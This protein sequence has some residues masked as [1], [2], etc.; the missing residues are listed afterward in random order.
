MDAKFDCI[1]QEGFKCKQP[2][3]DSANITVPVRFVN[4]TGSYRCK[5]DGI[6]LENMNPCRFNETQVQVSE[7]KLNSWCEAHSALEGRQLIVNCAF[8]IDVENF[9]VEYNKTV[10]A[11][12]TK[13][14]C[15]TSDV[16][17]FGHNPHSA[18]VKLD[19]PG[20]LHG[21][22]R[23]HPDHP[24]LQLEVKSCSVDTKRD[25]ESNVTGDD[26]TQQENITVVENSQINF[27]FELQS[28]AEEKFRIDVKVCQDALLHRVCG[29]RWFAVNKPKCSNERNNFTCEVDNSGMHM[30]FLV[31]RT[32]SDIFWMNLGHS[33]TPALLKH[34]QLQVTCPPRLTLMST[35]VV[36]LTSVAD[37][38]S[39]GLRSYTSN[40]TKYLTKSD[41]GETI[42]E[43]TY[44]LSGHPPM[45][46]L[47]LRLA[48]KSWT[49]LG[50]W[51]L[52]VENEFG[53][54]SITFE[55]ISTIT[56]T[57]LSPSSE[58]PQESVTT[59]A[60]ISGCLLS[61]AAFSVGILLLCVIKMR[62]GVWGRRRSQFLV[63]ASGSRD[64]TE[65][66]QVGGL[67]ETGGFQPISHTVAFG[68]ELMEPTPSPRRAD[69]LIYGELEF[70]DRTPSN[71]II[72]SL[73]NTQY[74]QINFADLDYPSQK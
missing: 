58:D 15:Q 28:I 40:I 34:T 65:E 10:V 8:S 71:V 63:P 32:D 50:N 35:Q 3:S 47:T 44:E 22:L 17:S 60:I 38:L 13:S 55:F 66:H 52:K 46:N 59:L 4:R 37:G 51:T 20:N 12:Y 24:T 18:I 74:A 9:T 29:C 57:D 2:V 49:G 23:C 64:N 43:V 72:G 5:T 19:N 30:S 54:T 7:N 25:T 73:P 39:V 31:K 56:Q 67:N 69:G 33:S 21:E 16:C 6:R 36:E 48:P 14:F 70:S 26:K 1:E 42:R 68:A 27:T 62:H 41:S 61:V 11:S 45:F 53:D